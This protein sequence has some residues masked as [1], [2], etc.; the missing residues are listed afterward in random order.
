MKFKQ[1]ALLKKKK[2]VLHMLNLSSMLQL[3]DI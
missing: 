1:L 3:T 2:N